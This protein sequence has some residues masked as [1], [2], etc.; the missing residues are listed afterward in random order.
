[1]NVGQRIR[2]FRTLKGYSINKLANLSG[3]SQSYL[4]AVEFEEKNPTI[5]LLTLL[6]EQLEV[7]LKDF[8]DEEKD[9][10][11]SSDPIHERIYK[12][13]PTQRKALTDFLDTIIETNEE[14]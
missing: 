2:H 1:M 12:L 4:R 14:K 8:F 3:I 5:Q 11:F 7:S 13:M 10:S 6:C 9:F